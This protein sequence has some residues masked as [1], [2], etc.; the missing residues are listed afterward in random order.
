MILVNPIKFIYVF[1]ASYFRGITEDMAIGITLQT[2]TALIEEEASG[3]GVSGDF[4]YYPSK[5]LYRG[6][7]V[8]GNAAFDIISYSDWV[9]R[10]NSSETQELTERPFSLGSYI[11]W[12]WW[13]GKEFVTDFTLG[14]EYNFNP[15]SEAILSPL[16]DRKGVIPYLAIRIG[17][18]W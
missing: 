3:F 12:N 13:W 15:T 18:A 6:F 5:K 10:P 7:H 9:F 16:G 4:V 14:T 1:N 2:P 8:G 17:H 11:G